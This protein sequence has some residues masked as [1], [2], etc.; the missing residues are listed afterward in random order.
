MDRTCPDCPIHSPYAFT[1]I[2]EGHSAAKEV[3]GY[4]MDEWYM[5]I[6]TLQ[7]VHVFAELPLESLQTS[8]SN[9]QLVNAIATVD[10]HTQSRTSCN[11]KYDNGLWLIILYSVDLIQ[12]YPLSN[13]LCI[14]SSRMELYQQ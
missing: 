3:M 11:S 13:S 8:S 12:T 4:C 2:P 1:P 10:P 14:H 6:N 9:F 7:L 5:Y